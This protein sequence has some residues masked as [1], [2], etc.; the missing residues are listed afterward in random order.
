MC[1]DPFAD[2]RRMLCGQ[3]SLSNRFQARP[4]FASN[5]DPRG[6]TNLGG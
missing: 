6:V 3:G 4:P 5:T 1:G 2:V